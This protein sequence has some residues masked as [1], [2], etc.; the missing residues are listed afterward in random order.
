MR[1]LVISSKEFAAEGNFVFWL[2][3]QFNST[4]NFTQSGWLILSNRISFPGSRN[5]VSCQ[6]QS[7]FTERLGS[8]QTTIVRAPI[9]ASA[10]TWTHEGIYLILGPF[11]YF[12][13]PRDPSGIWI[14]YIQY[15][16]HKNNFMSPPKLAMSMR[17]LIPLRH[18][19]LISPLGNINRDTH[20]S[21]QNHQT[22][23]T[24]GDAKVYFLQRQTWVSLNYGEHNPLHV[25]RY[26]LLSQLYHISI[27]SLYIFPFP[28]GLQH[29]RKLYIPYSQ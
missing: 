3:A 23:K 6:T 15:A 17:C 16:T 10:A 29:K 1:T 14:R 19:T 27:S 26:A 12:S 22:H 2:Y 13:R 25:Q 11:V 18:P 20:A 4:H 24:H 28:R 21:P 7:F 8:V 5:W 9:T